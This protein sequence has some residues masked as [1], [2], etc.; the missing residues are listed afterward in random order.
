MFT[1]LEVRQGVTQGCAVC[2]IG[3][4]LLGYYDGS[5]RQKVED[6]RRKLVASTEAG[7]LLKAPS[8][9]ESTPLVAGGR[10]QA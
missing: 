6:Q 4:A 3:L 5:G 2:L 8:A 10:T 1:S 9:T 7:G